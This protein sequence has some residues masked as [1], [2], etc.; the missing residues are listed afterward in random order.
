MSKPKEILEGGVTKVGDSYSGLILESIH[1][2]NWEGMLKTACDFASD[3][4]WQLG[5]GML[6][7][8]VREKDHHIHHEIDL[9]IDILI[10]SRDEVEK[11]EEMK[12][13]IEDSGFVF[14]RAQEYEGL[15]MSLLFIHPPTK[16]LIDYGIFYRFWGDDLLN[17]GIHGIVIRPA[18]SVESKQ[19]EI[20]GNKYNIPKEYD[21]YL[22]GRYGDWRTPR[23]SKGHW[24]EDAQKG[25]LFIPIKWA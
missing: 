4:N 19:I 10:E 7:G 18:Y 16:I 22:T 24:Y 1:G 25:N 8:A 17:I 20:N 11:L 14:L 9:D 21:K 15:K 23:K 5:F 13:K 12:K 6:L 2:K 3:F